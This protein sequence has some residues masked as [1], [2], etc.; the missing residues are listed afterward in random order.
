MLFKINRILIII[1]IYPLKI[2]SKLIR[3]L[4][5]SEGEEKLPSGKLN[6]HHF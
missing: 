6:I 5:T 4:K 1:K 3:F 2:T